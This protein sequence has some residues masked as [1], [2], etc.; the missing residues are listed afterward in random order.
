M[1]KKRNNIYIAVLAAGKGTRMK[2]EYPKVLHPICGK[3]MI[4][5]VLET[6]KDL[7]VKNIFTVIGHQKEVLVKA[8]PDQVITVIQDKQT[9]TG[10]A[11][12]G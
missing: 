8:L 7:A 4:R 5:Y 2:S 3:P 6:V 10:H 11:I 9:G 12:D 1:N